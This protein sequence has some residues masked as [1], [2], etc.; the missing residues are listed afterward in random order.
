MVIFVLAISSC[1]K[2]VRFT[3]SLYMS[4]VFS[5]DLVF[6]I[7]RR[8]ITNV[9]N[10]ALGT[11]WFINLMRFSFW[12]PITNSFIGY[13]KKVNTEQV[14]WCQIQPTSLFT[15][16]LKRKL[17]LIFLLFCYNYWQKYLRGCWKVLFHEQIIS[18]SV[19]LK[20]PCKMSRMIILRKNLIV[21]KKKTP[22][23]LGCK[24]V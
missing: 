16:F 17:Q 2:L 21:R 13:K 1:M 4:P 18:F 14:I 20:P 6:Y 12:N 8:C 15:C 10:R 23:N 24:L 22:K 3:S 9:Y 11:V 19:Q 5:V 7:Y